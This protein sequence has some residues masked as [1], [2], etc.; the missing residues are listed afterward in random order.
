[1]EQNRWKDL[2]KLQKNLI[3]NNLMNNLLKIVL[4]TRKTELFSLKTS[5]KIL[6]QR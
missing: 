4:Y 5:L 1:M 3:Q 6:E 2:V